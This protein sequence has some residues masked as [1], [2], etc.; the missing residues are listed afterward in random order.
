MTPPPLRRAFPGEE[1]V[2]A[3]PLGHPGPTRFLGMLLCYNDA[4]MLAPVLEHLIENRHDVVVWNHG[5]EDETD[6]IARSYLGRG[7]IEYQS[8]D[9]EAVPFK[10]LYGLCSDYLVAEFAGRYDWLSW[11]DQDE[12]LEGPDLTRP[13]HEQVTELLAAGRTWVEFDNYVFWFTDEDDPNEPDPVARLR[14][15]NLYVCP[16]RVRAWRFDRTNHR[17]LGNSN[18]I[19]GP[20]A[21]VNWP[22]RHYPMRTVEQARRRAEHDRN[23]PGFQ[24]SDKNWHYEHFRDDPRALMV[25]A[26]RLHRFD[27]TSLDPTVTHEF[28]KRPERLSGGSADAPTA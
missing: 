3:R 15:Y 16:P 24:F 13:Y 6:A 11:P 19:D 1:R 12:L 18:P 5:S 17:R 23:Q 28:Y 14:H 25:P 4:D 26:E 7:V 2:R 8:L 27:G 10:E 20:K 22:L 21:P 9:R